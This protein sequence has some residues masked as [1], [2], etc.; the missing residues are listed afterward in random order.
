MVNASNSNR[1]PLDEVKW[2]F[3]QI[4]AAG[5]QEVNAMFLISLYSPLD[6]IQHPYLLMQVDIWRSP[7]P[8]LWWPI[9][10]AWLKK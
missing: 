8:T 2:R 9:I 7:V 1:I 4:E 6:C 5:A 10:E 3:E